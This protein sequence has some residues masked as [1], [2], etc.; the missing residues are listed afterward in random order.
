MRHHAELS[1]DG[2]ENQNAVDEVITI[3]VVPVN[4]APTIDDWNLQTGD[5]INWASNDSSLI[6][7]EW[8]IRVLEDTEEANELTFDLS[9]LKNDVDHDLSDLTWSLL[10]KLDDNGRAYCAYTN[11]F[12]FA[13][14]GDE[15]VLDLV[16][17]ATTNAPINQID[18]LYNGGVHQVNPAGKGFCEMELYL[19]DSAAAPTGF[20][21][22]LNDNGYIQQTSL[23]RDVKIIVQNVAEQV[24]DYYFEA[25]S[26]FDFNGVSNVMDGTWVPVTVTV[27]AGGDEGPYN[28]DSMLM[29]TFQSDGHA[30]TERDAIY[31]D[32]P[33]YGQSVTVDSEVF[34][35]AVTTT[36]WAEMDVKTCV[37]ETCDMTKSVEDRFI[38]DEPASHGKVTLPNGLDYWAEP[39]FY[40][41]EDGT[42]SIRRPVLEDKDWCNNVMYNALTGNIDVCDQA[43]YGRGSSRSPT[44]NCL[45]LCAPSVLPV[46]HRSLRASSP[47]PSRAWLSASS[48]WRV[49]A[50]KTKRRRNP[51]H[52]SLKTRLLSPVIATI[53]MVA[54]TVVLSGV[55]YVWA[56]SLAETDVKGVPRITFQI[57]DVNAFDAET[58]H[59]KIEVQQSETELATQAVE[60]KIFAAEID[61][62]YEVK[63]AN[64]DGVYGFS[65]YNSDSLVTFSD[66]VRSE[67]D[68]KVST[69][70]VGDTI[71][72][73][74]HLADGTPLTDVTIQLSYAPEVGQGALLAPGVD[75]P[76]T[77]LREQDRYE[78]QTAMRPSGRHGVAFGPQPPSVG[79]RP[80]LPRPEPG[81]ALMV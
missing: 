31:I 58:G 57:E 79:E 6:Y 12:S 15:L 60:I 41:S 4:D 2:A 71:F 81:R 19:T 50:K 52:A 3:S 39:G 56:S 1:D 48:P 49:A 74:T 78:A 68:D 46:S 62:V 8:T 35:K 32:A 66:S 53:L 63:M 29:I 64:S 55:I 67:G 24:P 59:W 37:D 13:F 47:S 70:F 43:D 69:F 42:D 28:H 54:I 21:Y 75:C 80:A 40:G 18:Y 14:D 10:P 36:V 65:P 7:G 34:V 72:V 27:T 26:G 9:A 16:K 11:Y 44:R 76:T 45:T 73:R 77:S 5:T 38:A 25:N 33:A 17:D 23:K 30:E 20:A 61:G 22:D 51:P